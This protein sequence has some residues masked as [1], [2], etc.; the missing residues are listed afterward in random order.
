V[1]KHKKDLNLNIEKP[2][3]M[4]DPGFEEGDN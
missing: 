4:R 3:P 1:F 2:L